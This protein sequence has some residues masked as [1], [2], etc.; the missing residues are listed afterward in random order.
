[1]AYAAKAWAEERLAWKTVIQLNLIRHVVIILDLL[2][3]ELN[4]STSEESGSD[5]DEPSHP[6]RPSTTSAPPLRFTE[7]HRLLKLRLAPLR[8]V[9]ADL[10]ARLGASDWPAPRAG[11]DNK[12]R[13]QDFFV[14]SNA[15]WKS[16]LRPGSKRSLDLSRKKDHDRD[17]E[18]GEV[19]AS[20]AEDIKALWADG[21]VQEML[22]RRWLRLDLLPGL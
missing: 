15:G 17:Y 7:K 14:R 8:S 12:S 18:T 11:A 10:Q 13:V 5:S 6:S 1:M 9:Q 4:T 16:S 19:L 21:V 3:Q 20:C 22:R 2:S